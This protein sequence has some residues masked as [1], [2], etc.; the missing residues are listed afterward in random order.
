MASV[1]RKSTRP[2]SKSPF[3]CSGHIEVPPF[4]C[5]RYPKFT[6]KWKIDR[7][8]EATAK[9]FLGK[10]TQAREAQLGKIA[11][12]DRKWRERL[13]KIWRKRDCKLERFP[14]E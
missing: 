4:L 6:I 12:S 1:G 7:R 14:V 11:E 10:K 5:K 13:Y 9:N 3:F 2:L 8:T